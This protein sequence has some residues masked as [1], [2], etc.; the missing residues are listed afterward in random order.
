MQH[1]AGEPP[2]PGDVYL[3]NHPWQGGVHLPDFFFAKPVFLDGDDAP[4]A[5][6]VMVSHMVDVGG[7]FPGGVSARAASLWE[8]G[9]VLPRVTLVSGGEVNGALLDVI[10]ANSREPHKVRGDVRAV[11]A[12]LET[13][14]HQ[15][16][17]LAR[18]IGELHLTDAM[19]RLLEHT[20]RATRAA[21]A[22][23]P[24]GRAR[25]V[26]H[27][28]DDGVGGPPVEFACE[29]HKHGDRLRFDF[30]GTGPQ[31]AAGI[32][33]TISDVASVVAFVTR[34]A[35]GEVVEVNDGFYRCLEFEVPEGAIVNARYPAAVGA[36]ALPCTGSP[37]SRWPRSENSLPSASPRT[38]AGPG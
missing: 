34:A 35:I 17:D 2:Q 6:A 18:R 24:D 37:T 3:T 8:E 15:L 25:A 19:N 23:L 31:V 32:N 1:L 14:E 21:I 13:G 16:R 29:V 38:T 10:A 11:L 30:T 5:Y 22:Q 28:D 20:E 36:R 33:T 4:S 12:G 9:L 26:D 7:R 27:L